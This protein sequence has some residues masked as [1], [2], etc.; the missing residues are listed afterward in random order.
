MGFVDGF[1]LLLAAGFLA[2]SFQRQR[3]VNAAAF[4]LAL[5]LFVAALV[6]Q[7]LVSSLFFVGA[8]LSIVATPIAVV[9]L[10]ICFWKL[11]FALMMPSNSPLT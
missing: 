6:C 9:L 7:Y 2:T 11:C 5:N 3:V 8:Y 1:S 4:R 10:L